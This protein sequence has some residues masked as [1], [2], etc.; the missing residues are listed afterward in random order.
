MA[1]YFEDNTEMIE[2]RRDN[3]NN[4]YYD[5]NYNYNK[6]QTRKVSESSKVKRTSYYLIFG[7]EKITI[8]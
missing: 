6:P 8:R 7:N 5:Q 4:S 3:F 1:K 2:E